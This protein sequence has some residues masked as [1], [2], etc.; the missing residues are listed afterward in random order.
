MGKLVILFILTPILDLYILIKVSQNMGFWTTVLLI[1]L[2]GVAGYFLANSEGKV[3]LSRINSELSQGNIP[4]EDLLN[5]FCILIGGF[6]LLLPGIL[7]DIVGIT[8][9]LPGTRNLYKEYLRRKF[10]SK[11]RLGDNSFFFKRY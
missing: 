9:I 2:T 8:M 6:L 3:V 1:I 7:T 4:G 5:G 10:V 11:I